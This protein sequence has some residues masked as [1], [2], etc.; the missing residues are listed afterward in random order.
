MP[1]YVGFIYPR[2]FQ[3]TRGNVGFPKNTPVKS[4]EFGGKS[5]PIEPNNID[6]RRLDE[7]AQA[8][9]RNCSRFLL[10]NEVGAKALLLSRDQLYA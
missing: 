2:T 8:T 4:D 7:W 3:Y 9:T 5:Q 1:R 6:A 10:S